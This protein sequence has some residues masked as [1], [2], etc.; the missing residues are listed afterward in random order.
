MSDPI[1]YAILAGGILLVLI[2]VFLLAK[3]AVSDAAEWL[4][5]RSHERA[6]RIE[7]ELAKTKKRLALISE[8]QASLLD[9]NAH[10]AAVALILESYR[11]SHSPAVPMVV[12]PRQ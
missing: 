3:I 1:R 8:A 11:A 4:D 6:Q 2:L 12:S 5:R 10:E 7:R 9:A